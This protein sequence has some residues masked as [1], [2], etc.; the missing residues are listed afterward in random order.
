MGIIGVDLRNSKHLSCFYQNLYNDPG[1]RHILIGSRLRSVR[2]KTR[3]RRHHFKVL[4]SVSFKKAE[5]FQNLYNI[6]RDWAKD[7]SVPK[8]SCQG[9]EQ[10]REA[11][12][13]KTPFFITLKHLSNKRQLFFTP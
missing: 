4:S 1:Y 12:R 9:I 2:G 10:V 6:L 5:R 3:N 8:T 11:G 13:R 7:K